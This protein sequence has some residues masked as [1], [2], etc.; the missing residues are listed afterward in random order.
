MKKKNSILGFN[1]RAIQIPGTIKLI[2]KW[3]RRGYKGRHIVVANTHVL[4]Q[5][6]QDPLFRKMLHDSDAIIPDGM[7][8]IWILRF[9]GWLLRHRVSGPD[10]MDILFKEDVRQGWKLRHYFYGGSK[11]ALRLMMKKLRKKYP[12][13]ILCGSY[14]PPF[15][16]LT[17]EED[18]RAIRKINQTK[19]DIVWV[20]LGSPKQ[21]L[22]IYH[23]KKV[24]KA[25]V[26]LGVGQAFDLAAGRALRAPL[27]MRENG[28]EWLYRLIYN[29]RR[30]WKRYLIDGGYFVILAFLDIFKLKKFEKSQKAS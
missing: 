7:P 12:S 18:R 11:L 23:H 13:L 14:S 17:P 19:P 20:G 28:F 1:V 3:I 24:V 22:W 6:V 4:A 9:K 30:L 21:E 2:R 25:S 8:L 15:R 5:G 29:P 16:Q 10:L 26:F 27:W